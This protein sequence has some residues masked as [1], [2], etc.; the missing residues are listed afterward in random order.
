M[1][2]IWAKSVK[3]VLF[4]QLLTGRFGDA[5]VDDLRHGRAIMQR[6]HDIGWFQ[7]AMNDSLL[8]RVLHGLANMDEQ[9]QPLANAQVLLVA[10]T[11]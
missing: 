4:G 6:D 9:L 2:I 3:S 7:V 1:P 11:P 5:E 8:M 10:D